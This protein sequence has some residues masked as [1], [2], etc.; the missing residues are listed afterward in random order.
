M[1]QSASKRKRAAESERVKVMMEQTEEERRELRKN[2]RQL[3]DRIQGRTDEMVQLDSRAY[4]EERG[5][6]NELFK[7][8]GFTRELGNDGDNLVAI[9]ELATKRSAQLAH[10]ATSYSS[11]KIVDGLKKHYSTGKNRCKWLAL[12]EDVSGLFSAVPE[13]GFMF[14]SLQQPEKVKK[15]AE[16][17]KRK[18]AEDDDLQETQYETTDYSQ[19]APGDP[20][21]K[22]QE[23]ATNRRLQTLAALM[24]TKKDEHFDLVNLLVNPDKFSE[25]VENFFDL[26]FLVKDGKANID[27]D[28]DTGLPRAAISNPPDEQVPKS[29]TVVVLGANDNKR[30]AELW[31]LQG[32]MLSRED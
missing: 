11:Q 9:G 6:N 25:T 15:V 26:S 2:Q 20:Q 23:E 28:P 18:V 31:N 10:S 24:E 3:L 32:T 1:S 7:S 29:Q 17:K 13:L 12:G 19:R 21:A 27:I 30:L 5:Q 16:R 14:G 22:K 4:A 8:V